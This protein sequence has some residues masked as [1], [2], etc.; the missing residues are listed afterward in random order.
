[1]QLINITHL[2]QIAGKGNYHLLVF[3]ED[4]DKGAVTKMKYL[5]PTERQMEIAKMLSGEEITS[6]AME[7]ARELLKN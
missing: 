4:S 1:M 2:P 6:A 7:N 5:T 3:K